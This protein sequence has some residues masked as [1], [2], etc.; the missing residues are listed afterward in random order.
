LTVSLKDF[1][2]KFTTFSVYGSNKPFI[3]NYS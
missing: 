2:C 1:F 3:W